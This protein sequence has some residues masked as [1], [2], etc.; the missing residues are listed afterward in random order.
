[1]VVPMAPWSRIVQPSHCAMKKSRPARRSASTIRVVSLRPTSDLSGSC[2]T[3]MVDF[4]ASL[5]P[6]GSTIVARECLLPASAAAT[7]AAAGFFLSFR[8]NANFL[9]GTRRLCASALSSSNLANFYQREREIS[10]QLANVSLHL[11]VHVCSQPFSVSPF[12]L[13]ADQKVASDVIQHWRSPSQ[14]G[15]G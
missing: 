9:R 1:L 6:S 11:R 4:M 2:S 5:S 10:C 13:N 14:P 12:A 3:C 7:F 15:P 8:L